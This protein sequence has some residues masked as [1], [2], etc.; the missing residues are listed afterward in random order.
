[1][2]DAFNS[3]L[4]LLW[5]A[6]L[7]ELLDLL[8]AMAKTLFLPMSP[9]SKMII[10][11]YTLLNK[12]TS[13]FLQHQKEINRLHL[14]LSQSPDLNIFEHLWEIQEYRVCST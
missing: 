2:K 11:T 5:A 7:W 13:G 9:Y 14:Q 8:V 6:I 10:P 3:Q 4:L 12:C 1:M